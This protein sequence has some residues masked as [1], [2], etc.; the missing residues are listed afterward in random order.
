MNRRTSALW[1]PGLISLT[2]SMVWRL[3]LQET[4]GPQQKLLNHAGLPPLY[5]FLWVA[6]L[7]LFGMAS[8]YLARRGGGSRWSAVVA[9][10]FPSIL[11]IP[12]WTFLALKMSQPSPSQ[13]FGLLSGVVNWV[14]LPGLALLLGALPFLKKS[15]AA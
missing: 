15:D 1:M 9:A 11:M 2:G 6:A 3:I 5:Q 14:F 12:L 10:L 4:V 7:P 8:A 13:W